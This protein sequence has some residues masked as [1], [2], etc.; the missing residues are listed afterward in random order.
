V[1]LAEPLQQ[2]GRTYV[3]H[4][5]RKLSYFGGCDYFR[6]ASHPKVLR[7]LHEGAEQF[8]LNVAASRSTTGNHVL[9]GELESAVAKFFRAPAA[10]LFSNGYVTNF[11]VCQALA[12]EITHTLIDARSHASV[13]D[14]VRLLGC[15][16]LTFEHRSAHD[17]AAQV[18]KLRVN[19]RL[20]VV[21]DGMFS[22]DGSAAPLREY[23]RVLPR[24]ALL[25]VDDAH[26]GGVLG[27]R[28]G[29]TVE[30]AGVSRQRVIQTVALSKAFGCYGGAVLCSAKLRERIIERS[31]LFNGNTPLPL[32]L[33]NAALTAVELLKRN[34]A[35]RARMNA[36]AARV[37]QS[38][39][40]TGREIPDN[41]GPIISIA[42]GDTAEAKRLSARLLKH[43]VFPSFI[44]YANSTGCFRFMISSEHTREQL[45]A[46]VS[47]LDRSTTSPKRLR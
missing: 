29:G 39:R 5:G 11:G 1:P 43:G 8:G 47:V 25:L 22:H 33:A 31:R 30:H 36:N 21:T 4:R 20:L 27:E 34:P 10:V 44:R 7:A 28:G 45:D 3:L 23:L 46:L 38:L 15:D 19:A 14:A 13:A 26:G 12:G 32:P 2:V 24:S 35:W 37:K 40:E 9:F 42:P 18:K 17:L 6:L 16:V 41:P